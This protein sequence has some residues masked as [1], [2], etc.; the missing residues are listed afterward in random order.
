M[1]YIDKP[2][3][4]ISKENKLILMMGNFNINLLN[5]ESHSDTNVFLNNVISHYLLPH[6]LHPSRVTDH[7]ATVI[8]NIFSNNTEYNTL[9]GQHF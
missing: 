2:L 9:S 3:N 7:C 8:N 4:K 1:D 6:I 5:Y